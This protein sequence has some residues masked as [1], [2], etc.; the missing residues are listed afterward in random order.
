MSSLAEIR[1]AL[2]STIKAAVSDLHDYEVVP[3]SV[4]VPAFIVVPRSTDFERAF[5]R[6]LD[7]YTFD[8]IVVVSRADDR[9][10]Q[11]KVDPYITGAGSSSI[12]QAI[13]NTR[14]LGIGVEARVT[15]MTGYG[16]TLTFGTTDYFGARLTVE[17]LTSGTA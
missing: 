9:L 10:A 11:S 8:V 5:G 6:G 1:T 2:A 7:V 15:G 3:E 14:A 17:V 13:W 4:N 12:R 16:D